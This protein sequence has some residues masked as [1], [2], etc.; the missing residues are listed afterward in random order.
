VNWLVIL[1]W[2]TLTSKLGACVADHVGFCGHRQPS[3]PVFLAGSL[4]TVL[5]SI[6]LGVINVCSAFRSKKCFL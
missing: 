2:F 1:I 4:V 5:P 3:E 6:I